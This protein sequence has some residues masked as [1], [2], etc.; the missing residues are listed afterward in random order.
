MG[1]VGDG[2]ERA[3]QQAFTR[4]NRRLE[5]THIDQ[6]LMGFSSRM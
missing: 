2:L 6:K 3:V 5:P 4:P 1:I